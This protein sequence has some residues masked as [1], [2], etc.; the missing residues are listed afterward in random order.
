MTIDKQIHANIFNLPLW[1]A[2]FGLELL[3]HIDYSGC[4]TILDIGVGD[5]F[6]SFELSQRF[7]KK[8]V[9]YGIDVNDVSIKRLN[10][11]I[12]SNNIEN[13]KILSANAEKLPFLDETFDLIVSNNGI[14]NVENK[15]LAI[16]ECYRVIKPKSDF[17]FTFNLKDSLIQFYN[18]FKNVLLSL[19]L[20]NEIEDVDLHIQDKRPELS[21][22]K[23][24]LQNSNFSIIK[25]VENSFNMSFADSSTF[26]NH[27]WIKK[28][29]LPEWLKIVSPE[30]RAQVFKMIKNEL[31]SQFQNSFISFDI[32][33]VC[34]KCRKKDD[35]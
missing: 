12:L 18:I 2:P 29:F 8:S 21:L 30:H 3:R 35:K 19:C 20:Y 1:S 10:E 22:M 15:E 17:I 26:F 11:F 25:I 14:N 13:V 6:P 9:I 24:Y 33:F 16:N 34:V 5:G 32:P 31:D 7:D 4:K 27:Y 28:Y 23:K